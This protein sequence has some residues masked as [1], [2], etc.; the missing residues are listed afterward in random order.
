MPFTLTER[1]EPTRSPSPASPP[2]SSGVV[3]QLLS[4]DRTVAVHAVQRTNGV[5][6]VAFA[7]WSRWGRHPNPD[8]HAW[9]QLAASTT[10]LTDSIDEAITIGKAEAIAAGIT[11]D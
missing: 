9:Q 11:F 1:I 10:V 7:A 6:T 2:V 8:D 3:A 5:F 4:A